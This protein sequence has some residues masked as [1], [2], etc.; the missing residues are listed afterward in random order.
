MKVDDA[1]LE[2]NSLSGS[3]VTMRKFNARR[4]F[5]AAAQ[6]IIMTNRIRALT[7]AILRQY[8]AESNEYRVGV[9]AVIKEDAAAAE[10]SEL[11]VEDGVNADLAKLLNS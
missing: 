4:R 11:S 9:D 5:K 8:D 6:A 3:Q 2:G 7:G 1:T 10:N